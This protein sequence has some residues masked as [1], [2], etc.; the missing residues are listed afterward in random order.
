MF[1]SSLSTS[2]V[3]VVECRSGRFRQPQPDI[4]DVALHGVGLGRGRAAAQ[5]PLA[6]PRNLLRGLHHPAAAVIRADALGTNHGNE[7][8]IVERNRLGITLGGRPPCGRGCLK[9]RIAGLH[10][11]H[12][13]LHG[14][15]RQTVGTDRTDRPS[16]RPTVEMRPMARRFLLGTPRLREPLAPGQ[17]SLLREAR[18]VRYWLLA[19]REPCRPGLGRTRAKWSG[20]PANLA[21]AR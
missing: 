17:E 3:I 16:G 10:L 21:E 8:G 14:Q 7:H 4:A 18:P 20:S 6:R 13:L 9:R 12:Q 19:E 11:R 5:R 15:F 2:Q 1:T